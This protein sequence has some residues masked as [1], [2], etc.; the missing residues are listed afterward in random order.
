[1]YDAFSSGGGSKSKRRFSKTQGP[2]CSASR[3]V[4]Y[5]FIAEGE[6]SL[7]N[8]VESKRASRRIPASFYVLKA[9]EWKRVSGDLSSGGALV[10]SDEKLVG[11]R[12]RL[13]IQLE[14]GSGSWQVS[15]EILGHDNRGNRFGHHVRFTNTAEVRGLA[16]AIERCFEQ[17]DARLPTT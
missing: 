5:G 15:G 11:N 7:P 1:M 13:L 14:D 10:L 12:V 4:R 17:G 16:E 2:I 3:G 8:G 6:R 9:G